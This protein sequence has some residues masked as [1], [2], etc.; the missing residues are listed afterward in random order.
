MSLTVERGNTFRRFSAAG[1]ARYLI[2][3]RYEVPVTVPR[4]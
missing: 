3:S 2:V 4:P 1:M